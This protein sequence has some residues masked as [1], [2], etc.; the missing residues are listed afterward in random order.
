MIKRD[1]I[2]VE[3]KYQQF[4]R[5]STG[6]DTLQSIEFFSN[7]KTFVYLNETIYNYR[8]GSGMTG[9]FDGNYY[10]TF[11]KYSKNNK[12]KKSLEFEKLQ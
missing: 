4:G 2:D 7:A 1:C 11:K 12:R 6:E 9:K 8:C 3:K 5:I 10:F